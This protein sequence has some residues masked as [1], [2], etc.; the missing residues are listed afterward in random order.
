[1][2]GNEIKLKKLTI[3]DLVELKKLSQTTY[4]DAFSSENSKENMQA[5]LNTAFN[6]QKLTAE[7]NEKQS[8]F[9]FAKYHAETVGYLKVNFG[10]AQNDLFD[11]DAMELERIY[12]TKEYQGNKIGK[13]L[14]A[15]ALEIAKK[16]NVA[17]LWLGVWE[18]NERAI[19][20][21]KKEGFTA[22]SSH[23]FKMG[24]EI[25]TDLL[26]KLVFQ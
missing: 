10:T 5:Y 25:Q 7:L 9:Y 11:D 20:F 21:Y 22:F 18:K 1:M 2:T 12:V 8:D 6:D 24:N 15:S 16:K 26:M 19:N 23:S 3:L 4:V 17:Y 14:L 13:K